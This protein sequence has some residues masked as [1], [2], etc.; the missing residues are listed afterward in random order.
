MKDLLHVTVGGS[1]CLLRTAAVLAGA[2][3]GRVPI[4]PVVLAVRLLIV[5]VVL[6]R[7]AEQLCKGPDIGSSCSRDLHSRPGSRA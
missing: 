6:L 7:F 3:V 4:P 2:Q 5:A 1:R